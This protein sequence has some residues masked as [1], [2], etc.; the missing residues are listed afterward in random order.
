MDKT[1]GNLVIV[2]LFSVVWKQQ[3]LS[4]PFGKSF[5]EGLIIGKFV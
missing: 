5:W 3:L 1:S 2:N 4:V